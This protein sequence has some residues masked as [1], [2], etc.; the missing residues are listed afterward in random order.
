VLAA[1]RLLPARQREAVALRHC[2]GLTE[3]ETALT[4][5]ISRGTVKSTSSRGIAS[6]AKLLKE[7]S[8]HLLCQPH[9]AICLT[10]CS[11]SAA[12]A[13]CWAGS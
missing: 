9:A 2:L 11:A 7:D 12:A 10:D 8:R 5:E 13:P 1:L 4:M 6:L 3:H